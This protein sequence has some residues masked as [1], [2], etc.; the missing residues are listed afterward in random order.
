MPITR[1]TALLFLLWTSAAHAAP[2]T[3]PLSSYL[4]TE[5][6]S[7]PVILS[8]PHGGT[9]AVQG[10]QP[11]SAGTRVRDN[12]V[13]LLAAAIQRRLAAKTGERAYLVVARA[14]RKYVDF[15]R[16]PAR[17]YEDIAVKPLYDA[18]YD[19]L[20]RDVAAVRSRPGAVLLDIHGQGAL[21][22]TILRGTGDGLT[23]DNASLY[24]APDGFFTRLLAAGVKVAPAQAQG[25]EHPSFDGGNIV[26]TFG[27]G[28]PGGI[29]CIQL[30]FGASWR[31]TPA[32][33]EQAADLVSDALVAWL[34]A[35]HAL[36]AG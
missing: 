35:A 16:A 13:D 33:I 17:A 20:A 31:A 32:Q 24:A 22:D 9:Q 7:L 34:R 10:V 14:S 18:Y 30:E 21:P 8:A 36:Q 1:L 11:R 15:N 5:N 2:A 25:R 26:R 4:T 3:M 6:G 29:D 27:R 28:S 23:A 12:N 19:A